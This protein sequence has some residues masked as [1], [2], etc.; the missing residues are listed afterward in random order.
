M[1]ELV[2]RWT[3]RGRKS[4]SVD[5]LSLMSEMSNTLLLLW[6]FFLLTNFIKLDILFWLHLIRHITRRFSKINFMTDEI[7]LIWII[8]RISYDLFTAHI[9]H[10]EFI[11]L[12]R[13]FNIWCYDWS[14]LFNIMNNDLLNRLNLIRYLRIRYVITLF[15]H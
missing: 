1:I 14:I 12:G 9:I 6:I 8:K 4:L 15:F 2:T 13:W 5:K 3:L 11:S 10:I 7:T